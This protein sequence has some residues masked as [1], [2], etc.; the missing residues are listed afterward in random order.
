MNFAGKRHQSTKERPTLS[1]A[2]SPTFDGLQRREGATMLSVVL[3]DDHEVVRGGFRELLESEGD[4]GVVG[5]ASRK[6]EVLTLIPEKNPDVV[7]LDV[8][9]HNTRPS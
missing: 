4:I 6:D 1:E 8:R 7:L 5:K 3:V 9:L 2:T